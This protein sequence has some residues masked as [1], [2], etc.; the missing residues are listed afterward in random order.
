MLVNILAAIGAI[1]ATAA[2]CVGL[3]V[4]YCILYAAFFWGR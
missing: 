1:G 3:W 2:L 4:L